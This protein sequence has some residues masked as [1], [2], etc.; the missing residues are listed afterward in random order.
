MAKAK[1]ETAIVK[2]GTLDLANFA[3]Y[4]ADEGG[5]FEHQTKADIKVPFVVLL[6]ALSP[7]VVDDTDGTFKAGKWYNTVTQQVWDKETG[8]LFVPATTRHYFAEWTPRDGGGAGFQGHHEIDSALVRD[9]IARSKLAG[10]PFGQNKLEN[11]NRLVETFYVHGVTCTE[12]GDVDGMGILGFKSTHIRAYKTWNSKMSMFRL[13]TTS[14]TRSVPPLYAHLTRILSK[15]EKNEKG[16]FEIPVIHPAHE[17]GILQSLLDPSD[18][19]FQAAK[20]LRELVDAGEASFDPD[21]STGQETESD[22]E[23]FTTF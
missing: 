2:A 22:K 8:F 6:Q 14:G 12:D 17:K 20:S 10:L 11:G 19:R 16:Q 5:G 9:T 21:Q 1:S 15:H 18:V 3:G 23:P 13:P 7:V 4:G